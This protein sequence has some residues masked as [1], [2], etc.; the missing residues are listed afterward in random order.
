MEY[1]TQVCVLCTLSITDLGCTLYNV[2]LVKTT[3]KKSESVERKRDQYYF[4]NIGGAGVAAR[5]PLFVAA[6]TTSEHGDT[7][8]LEEHVVASAEL[9][10]HIHTRLPGHALRFLPLFING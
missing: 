5:D 2:Q 4:I 1:Y 7:W 8:W 9:L 10:S 3:T 6:A